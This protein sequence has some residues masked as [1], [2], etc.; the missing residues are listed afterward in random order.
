MD[1]FDDSDFE[2]SEYSEVSKNND[3]DDK[4]LQLIWG[5][6]YVMIQ[7]ICIPLMGVMMKKNMRSLPHMKVERE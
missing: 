1:N 2:S 4:D 5:M 7:T 6:K 3:N